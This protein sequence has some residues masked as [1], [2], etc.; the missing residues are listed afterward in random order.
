MNN[1]NTVEQR[2][3]AVIG[4]AQE[5]KT[6]RAENREL[7]KYLQEFTSAYRALKPSITSRLFFYELA[8]DDGIEDSIKLNHNM[9]MKASEY[10]EQI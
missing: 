9:V 2:A 5:N 6:L 4:L 8:G 1:W 3:E 7:R 10:M